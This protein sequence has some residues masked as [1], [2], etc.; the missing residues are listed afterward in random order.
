MRFTV[1]A[2]HAKQGNAYSGASGYVHESVE[3]RLIKDAII[4]YL[5]EAGHEVFDCTVDSG[6]SQSGIITEI[7]RKI[8]SY[9]NIAANISVHL[10]A[11]TTSPSDGN[12]KG[13]E[14]CV[15]SDSGST[16]EMADR[17][18]ANIASLG[19]KNRGNKVRTDLGVL[20]GIRNGGINIL[21]ETF[22]CDDE[23]DVRAYQT[24]GGADAF[25]KAIA[26]GILNQKIDTTNKNE[27]RK[28]TMQ[29]FYTID[30][31]GP[32][33][34][35]DGMNFH[36]LA[37]QDEMT[38]LNSIYKDNNGKD[39]PCYSWSSNAPWYVRLRQAMER[40]LS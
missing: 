15:Y 36:P 21:V 2:G 8:N 34:Y 39:M 37:H 5:R 24:C 18:C 6:V 38:V 22:F 3:N 25:G 33:I 4:K 16:K 35:F 23:D 28:T 10:N 9:T 30:G 13:T 19:F 17:I 29:C 27:R 40:K 1:H 12:T 14:C 31:K 7:K 11:C 26:V 32:V 20:N